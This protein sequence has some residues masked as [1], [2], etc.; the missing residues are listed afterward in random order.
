MLMLRKIFCTVLLFAAVCATEGSALEVSADSAALYDVQSG[1]FYYEKNADKQRGMAS[2]TKIMTA[3]IALENCKLDEIVDVKYEY[4]AVE[5][6]KMYLNP[7][8][9]VSVKELLYGLLL[10]SGN[11]AAKAI[12]GHISGSDEKFAELMNKKAEKLGLKSTSFE[13]PS[14][15]DG[16][17]HFTTAKELALIANYAMSIPQFRKI[18]ATKSMKTESGR[19]LSNHNKMLKLY[20]GADG[21]KTGFTQKCGRCLVS[22]AEKNGRRLIAVTLNAPDDWND[23]TNMLN[24]GFSMFSPVW[25]CEENTQM[26]EAY[27]VSRGNIGVAAKEALEIYLTDEEKQSLTYSIE[28]TQMVYPPVNQGDKYGRLSVRVDGKEIASTDL[29]Y[30]E[31]V[32]PKIIERKKPGIL[33]KLFGF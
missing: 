5:G 14:G 13:N 3:I 6:S 31:T 30:T 27:I 8:E 22:S 2:T 18:A 32:Q 15:L 4:A 10:S 11:D 1:K 29:I 23:H 16:E 25:V 26:G 9:E 21:V 33:A 28:G 12:A 7:G 20:D 17:N 19:Y 24:Y